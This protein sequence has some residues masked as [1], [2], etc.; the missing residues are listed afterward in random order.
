VAARPDA[1]ESVWSQAITADLGE[2]A[3]C[4]RLSLAGLSKA[5]VGK[6]TARLFRATDAS[7]E[8]VDWLYERSGGNPLFT[9]QLVYAL[10]GAEGLQIDPVTRQVRL[11]QDTPSLPASIREILLSRVDQLPET[12]RTVLKQAAVIGDDFSFEVLLNLSQLESERLSQHLERLVTGKFIV[13]GDTYVFAHA[14]LREVVYASLPYARRRLWHRKIA[15][16]VASVSPKVMGEQLDVLAVHYQHSDH[17]VKGI[18]YYQ[19]AGDQ[20][21][22]RRDWDK[23]RSYYQAIVD[24]AEDEPSL[25]PQ[26]YAASQAVG[27]MHILSGQPAQA[28]GAYELAR[29]GLFNLPQL[30]ARLAILLAAEQPDEAQER[31]VQTWQRLE[32][33]AW[34]PWVAGALAWLSQAEESDQSALAE[35]W[36]QRGL[37]ACASDEARVA[38]EGV[39]AGHFLPDFAL[40]LRLAVYDIHQQSIEGN[41]P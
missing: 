32:E 20:A 16:Y 3:S 18:S 11:S 26:R 25:A 31:L 2:P 21:R 13:P 7:P 35:T 22:A 9:T 1:I 10:A 12:T 19:L 27:D 4:R 40:W 30:D 15:D 38:L 28:L 33:D 39:R 6:L 14:L 5:Q 29:N 41:K 24:A 8:L 17:P 23:A 36:W 34:R 37:E